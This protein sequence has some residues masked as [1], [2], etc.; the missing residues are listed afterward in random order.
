[1]NLKLSK[2]KYSILGAGIVGLA[3]TLRLVEVIE[4][5]N[6]DFDITIIA[7]S[8]GTETTSDGAGGIF[9][10]DDRFMQGIAKE[11]ARSFKYHLKIN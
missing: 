3:T 4:E 2:K 6:K 10:P 5:F 9:R 7:E 8:F 11:T 1:M